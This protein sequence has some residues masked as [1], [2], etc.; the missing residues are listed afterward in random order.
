M[1]NSRSNALVDLLYAECRRR[2]TKL[3]EMAAE[4]G[5]TYSYI[6]HLR[7][8]FRS[9]A[10]INQ[11]TVEACARYLRVPPICIKLVTG[12]IRVGDFHLHA[13]TEEE[14]VEDTIRYM[15]ADPSVRKC[16]PTGVSSLS[17]EAKGA[18]AKMYVQTSNQ[19]VLGLNRLP[20][21]AQGL[22]RAVEA[23]AESI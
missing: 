1:G 12:Q 21:I 14:A 7:S 4:I 9:T 6:G 23:F 20:V 11:K 22:Q 13:L 18:L 2:G 10:A 5:V 3:T 15:D 16:F 17:L 19:D 8:G